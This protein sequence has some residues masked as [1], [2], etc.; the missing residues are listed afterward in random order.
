MEKKKFKLTHLLLGITGLL[1]VQAILFLL[2]PTEAVNEGVILVFVLI[3]VVMN[4]YVAI[5]A[6][7]EV[8]GHLKLLVFLSLIVLEFII[9]FAFEYWYLIVIQPG[10]FPTLSA[11]FTTLVLHSTMVFVFN[12]IYLPSTFAGRALLLINTLG[13][14]GMVLFILQ[15]VW[16][17]HPKIS[18]NSH[19]KLPKED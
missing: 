2:L 18:N 6:I 5:E 15:N 16:Q 4:I 11:D 10:S 12:P 3:G 8:S 1:L 13:G 14:L 9:F 7:E 17:I 19:K